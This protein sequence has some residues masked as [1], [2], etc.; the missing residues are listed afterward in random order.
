MFFAAA[1]AEEKNVSRSAMEFQLPKDLDT[2]FLVATAPWKNT[3][4]DDGGRIAIESSLTAL[5]S[6]RDLR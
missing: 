4:S 3:R 2:F 5:P 1:I 6:L